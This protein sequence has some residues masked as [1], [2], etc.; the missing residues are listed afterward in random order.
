M[1]IGCLQEA[2]TMEGLMVPEN[3]IDTVAKD[4]Q[5]DR[6]KWSFFVLMSQVDDGT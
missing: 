6:S 5:S 2:P 4:P 3:I 1:R